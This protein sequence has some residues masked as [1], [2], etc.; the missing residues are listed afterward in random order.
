VLASDHPSVRAVTIEC[1]L[2]FHSDVGFV[3][4]NADQQASEGLLQDAT[5]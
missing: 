1:V 5:C 2:R 3:L 4:Q